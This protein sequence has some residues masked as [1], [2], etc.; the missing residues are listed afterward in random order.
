MLSIFYVRVGHLHIFFVAMSVQIFVHFQIWVV[1]LLFDCYLYILDA[2]PL[3]EFW[4]EN[5][6]SYSVCCLLTLLTLFFSAQRFLILMTSSIFPFYTFSI[7]SKKLMPDPRS[8]RFIVRFFSFTS[9][10]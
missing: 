2:S 3:L 9:Y 10:I 8:Q 6:F 4:L 7:K 1:F 5:I